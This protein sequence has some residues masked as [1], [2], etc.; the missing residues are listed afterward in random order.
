MKRY[1][2]LSEILIDYRGHKGIAQIDLAGILDV[3]VRTVSRWEKG[4]SL[5]KPDKEKAFAEILFIPYMVLRHLNSENPLPVYYNFNERIY[6]LNAIGKKIVDSSV[7]KIDL[8]ADDQEVSVPGKEEDYSFV[9][10]IVEAKGKVPYASEFMLKKAVSLL[11]ELNLILFDQAGTYA[12]CM[13][14]LPL[15]QK[16]YEKIKNNELNET[17][18]TARDLVDNVEREPFVYFYYVLYADSF[19][20]TYYLTRHLFSQLQNNSHKQDSIFAGVSCT[21]NQIRLLTDMGLKQ[22]RE[23]PLQDTDDH[24]GLLLEGRLETLQVKQQAV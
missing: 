4:V 13:A 23:E 19:G 18:I 15:K 6:S 14:V 24:K 20:S 11:P 22:Y 5:I 12:G 7:F 1:N 10:R 17:V 21:D 16:V 2:N 8:P 9:N 3:D